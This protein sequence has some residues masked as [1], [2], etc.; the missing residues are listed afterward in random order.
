MMTKTKTHTNLP[1]KVILAIFMAV[2]AVS[3]VFGIATT[4]AASDA[5]IKRACTVMLSKELA[6]KGCSDTNINTATTTASKVCRALIQR[7]IYSGTPA[8]CMEEKAKDY[9]SDASLKPAPPKSVQEFTNRLNRITS[10]AASA[11]P[12]PASGTG[13]GTGTGDSGSGVSNGSASNKTPETC[14]VG[15]EC[16]LVKKYINPSIKL[17]SILVGVVAVAS[18]VYGGIMYSMSS[19]D[20]QRVAKAK[21]LILKTIVGI[22][23]YFMFF[24]FISFWIPGGLL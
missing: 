6:T 7:Q 5:T 14:A 9:L 17:L 18:I 22:I 20:P 13:A 4:S 1:S 16:D 12:T 2:F 3:G 10:E 24:G 8:E 19:G 15:K 11:V 21:G 23:A